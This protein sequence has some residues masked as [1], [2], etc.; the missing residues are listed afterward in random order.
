MEKLMNV[1]N[2]RSDSIDASKIEGSVRRIEVE[3]VWCTMNQMKIRKASGPIESGV[4]VKLF[5]A[6]G[7]K[8]FKSVINVFINILFKNTGGINIEFVST[9]FKRERGS[10]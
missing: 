3:E 6:G 1:E 10:L 4:S 5:R 8:F 7:D 2:E 9:N